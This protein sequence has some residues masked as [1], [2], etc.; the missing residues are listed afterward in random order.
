MQSKYESQIRLPFYEWIQ[1]CKII[2][3]P[4]QDIHGTNLAIHNKKKLFIVISR[5]FIIEKNLNN[6]NDHSK[7]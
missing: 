2:M 3:Q 7:C 1:F 6:M 4:D 5:S